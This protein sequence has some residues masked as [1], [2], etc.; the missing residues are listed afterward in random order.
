[1]ALLAP[2]GPTIPSSALSRLPWPS[3]TPAYAQV[4]QTNDRQHLE[5]LA[6]RAAERIRALAAETDELAARER[7]LLVELREL[8]VRRQIKVEELARMSVD[9]DAATA[10]LAETTTRIEA[11]EQTAIEQRPGV[12]ARLVE[13]Y[14]LGPPRYVRLLLGIDDL[15]SVGRAYRMVSEMAALDRRRI[16]EHQTTLAELAVTRIALEEERDTLVALR[17]EAQTARRELDRAVARQTELVE[18]IDERRDLTAQL[19]G[20]MQLAHQQLQASISVLEA[21]AAMTAASLS[22]PLRPFQ[23]DLIPPVAG[24]VTASFGEQQQTRFG[25][26]I[27]R[28]GVEIAA[29]EGEPVL[30]IHEGQVAYADTFTGFGNLIILDHGGQ[31]YSLYGYLA[32]LN[33]TA[34]AQVDREAP[35]GTVGRAPGGPAALLL[36][37]P[38]RR[39]PGRSGRMAQGVGWGPD[40][41]PLA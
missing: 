20:E 21:G 36:R 38:D 31:S 2:A 4:A 25:T 13:L 11:L 41:P 6:A 34:G 14:K 15:R 3:L 30:A 12:E 40:D 26:T 10:A 32:S 33:V 9:V 16:E 28:N 1:M 22:L 5:T 18:S 23:G 39:L 7:T 27:H 8:D 17:D 24:E 19:S 35:L 37:A 29:A